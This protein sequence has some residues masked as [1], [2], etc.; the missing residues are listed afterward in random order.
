[1]ETNGSL[2]KGSI[3]PSFEQYLRFCHEGVVWQF[4]ALPFWV[5][6][7]TTSVYNG[8]SICRVLRPFQWG[9]PPRPSG[10]L[11]DWK[12]IS[13]ELAKQQTQWSLDLCTRLG[14]VLN[15][16]KSSLTP[17]HVAIFLGFSLDT[18]VGL[19]YPSER[20]IERLLSI[21]EDL[22]AGQAQPALLWLRL[23]GHLASPREVVQ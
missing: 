19:A 9:Q 12:P 3:H 5:K 18:R 23:L 14:W 2:L 1:M 7:S 4:L 15:V 21:S 16:E 22:L 11:A 13:E 10:R 8:H 17:S 20:R 6:H